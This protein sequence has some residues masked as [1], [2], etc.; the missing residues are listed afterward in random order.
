MRGTHGPLDRL[1]TY[2]FGGGGSVGGTHGP[3]DGLSTYTFRGGEARWVGRTV[4]PMASGLT[5]SA[6]VAPWEGRTAPYGASG[7][8]NSA[9][10][11]FRGWGA[12]LSTGRLELEIRR[13]VG[14]VRG[15]H[16]PPD[17]LS[18]YKF[19]G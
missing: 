2:I 19:G 11:G 7:L 9:A 3:P 15:T 5:H 16:G 13:Q 8:T 17:G 1:W 14:S 6:A 12:R 18:S 10:G 4:P